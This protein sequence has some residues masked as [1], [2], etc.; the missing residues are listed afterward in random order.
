M[1]SGKT[2]DQAVFNASLFTFAS[3]VLLNYLGV[4]HWLDVSIVATGIFSG[5]M[6]SP[7]LDLAENAWKGD[8]SYK[9]TALRRWGLLSLFWLP[10][11][12]A[13]PH[14][15]WLSHGLIV[16]TSLRV[17]YFW[18]IVYGLSYA[19]WLERFINREYMLTMWRMFPVQLWFIGLCIADTIH[20]MFDGGKTSNHGKPFKGAKK[21]QRG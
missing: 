5:L 6:L 21:R 4:F 20:L 2:H 15:S 16:G 10:Y 14:R 19:P 17:L 9:V 11:G 3:G 8:S 13:I 12:L 1:A 18:G 7:D